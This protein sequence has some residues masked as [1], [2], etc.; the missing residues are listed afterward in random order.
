MQKDEIVAIDKFDNK[1]IFNI[2]QFGNINIYGGLTHKYLKSIDLSLSE[3]LLVLDVR[4][5]NLTCLDLS[6]CPNLFHLRCYD[7]NLTCLDL[8]NCPKLFIL[9]CDNILDI[10][11][12]KNSKIT[13]NIFI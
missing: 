13:I 1:H 2:D 6:N 12:Y 11:E 5:N 7:N 9:Y 3:K 4:Y 10:E 8:S